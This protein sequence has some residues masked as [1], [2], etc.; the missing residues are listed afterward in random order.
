[1]IGVP[2]YDFDA[3]QFTF[4]ATVP[5]GTTLRARWDTAHPTTCVTSPTGGTDGDFVQVI[6]GEGS[7][8]IPTG[9]P[10]CVSFFA[11]DPETHGSAAASPSPSRP[12]HRRSGR[13]PGTLLLPDS[14]LRRATR[15]ARTS[16]TAWTRTRTC[17]PAHP[18]LACHAVLEDPVRLR[19]GV[20]E[21]QTASPDQ[22][23]SFF[24]LDDQTGTASAPTKSTV[25]APLPTETSDHGSRLRHGSVYPC[26]EAEPGGAAAGNKV[27]YA[28]FGGACPQTAPAVTQWR[29]HLP[30][31]LLLRLTD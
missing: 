20:A 4:T 7:L 27:G 3:E 10:Q 17:A 2:S 5:A 19:D 22:C 30:G 8:V 23:V 6:N 26:F 12:P 25:N 15:P 28:V 31:R 13:R 11:T 29:T 21:F 9:L 16:S 18:P 24:A 1:M 14:T